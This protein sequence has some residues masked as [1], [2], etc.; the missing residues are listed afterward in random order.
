LF[1][2]TKGHS[3]FQSN[4]SNIFLVWLIT[5]TWT[6]AEDDEE[7]LTWTDTVRESIHA[8]NL[9]NGKGQDIIYMNDASDSQ[10]LA[11]VASIPPANLARLKDIRQK[12]DPSLVFT[13]LNSGDINLIRESTWDN[14]SSAPS[15]ECRIRFATVP[16][17]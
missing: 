17:S 4:G 2:S 14:F 6:N 11:A 5:A 3:E 12:Y 1:L 9:A 16:M 8:T 10:R 15:I 7:V 13:K